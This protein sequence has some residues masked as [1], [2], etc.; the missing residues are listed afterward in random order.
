MTC[1]NEKKQKQE[2]NEKQKEREY[3]KDNI[4][5][6]Q[7]KMCE[8]QS[9]LMFEQGCNH[10]FWI[11][12]VYILGHFIL[13]W[14]YIFYILFTKDRMFQ[15]FSISRTQIKRKLRIDASWRFTDREACDK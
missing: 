8:M 10:H 9:G 7:H 4:L 1:R 14:L 15:T 2:Q 13:F 12:F 5:P 3:Q 6:K 11:G